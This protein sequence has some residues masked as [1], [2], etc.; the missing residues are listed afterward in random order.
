MYVIYLRCCQINKIS[1]ELL[2]KNLC[3]G[4]PHED[5]T[6]HCVGGDKWMEKGAKWISHNMAFNLI[7]S[8]KLA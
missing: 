8:S 5:L 2:E 4:Y 6:S 3:S 7:L 1:L